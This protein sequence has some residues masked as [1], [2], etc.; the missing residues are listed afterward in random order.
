MINLLLSKEFQESKLLS[1]KDLQENILSLTARF[2]SI[3]FQKKCAG[4]KNFNSQNI[5]SRPVIL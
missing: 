3:K 4:L 1:E 5:R 2:F